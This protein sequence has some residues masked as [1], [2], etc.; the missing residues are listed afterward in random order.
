[1]ATMEKVETVETLK[2]LPNIQ[3][4]ADDEY[5]YPANIINNGITPVL[6]YDDLPDD[7]PDEELSEVIKKRKRNWIK[8]KKVSFN[9]T[10]LIHTPLKALKKY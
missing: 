8:F 3:G 2:L 9:K 4:L 6:K 1:M 5:E 7:L 10:F